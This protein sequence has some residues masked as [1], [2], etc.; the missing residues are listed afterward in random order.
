[1][2]IKGALERVSKAGVSGWCVDDTSDAPAMVDV[3]VDSVI[4]AT[5]RADIPRQDIHR[6][7]GRQLAG[8]RLPFAPGLFRLLPHGTRVEVASQGVT[9]PGIKQQ[10]FTIDNPDQDNTRLLLERLN[11]GYVIS[12]K[13]GGIFRPLKGSDQE[14]KA[15]NALEQGNQIFEELFGKQFFI[16]YG[17]LLGCIRTNDF[18]END[19]D[20]DVCFLADGD[21]LDAAAAEFADV[22]ASLR[23]RGETVT[24]VS[25]IQFHW[26]L[27]GMEIDVFMAWLEGGRLY[28]YNV[29]REFSKDRLYP[30]ARREFK[31]RDVLIPRDPEGLLEVIY[32]PDWRIPDPHFQWRPTMDARQ[33]MR[34]V[35]GRSPEQDVVR[36]QIRRHWAT[37]YGSART[38]IPSPFAASVAVELPEG[39][40]VLDLGCGNGRDSWFFAELGHMVL[41][42]DLASDVVE[43]NR[44]RAQEQ[45]HLRLR[46]EQRDISDP[47][48]LSAAL[49][50]FLPDGKTP[51]PTSA[52]SLAVYARFLL[53]AITDEQERA[54]IHTLSD[55]LPPGVTCYF[56]FRTKR[57]TDTQ[58]EF[59]DH[60]RR[61][62]NADDF[63]QRATSDG[64]LECDY[65][66]EG[67]G[68]AK[69]RNE[70]P[71][72]G[73]VHLRRT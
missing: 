66:V 71:V 11:D 56:E 20:I 1:M 43:R 23:G 6:S 13:S 45:Q 53:H 8:F 59:G 70:D 31:G 5:V 28:S 55:S 65:S 17:T 40:A 15:F 9:L 36:E 52:P 47:G 42:I 3:F 63:V 22:V 27:A 57:D 41:G 38:T 49:A 26:W 60:Y 48:A 21:S 67:R 68:M 46:F 33:K 16:C 73:R 29:G 2:A 72:V 37:F 19:D 24:L 39:C 12:P 58:K 34:E 61:Y 18:I 7:L 44:A 30:L 32:G 64:A 10:R 35:N 51:G 25:Q 54:L 69:F 62:I 4:L 14:D 50:A